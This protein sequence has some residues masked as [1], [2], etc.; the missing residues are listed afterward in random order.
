IYDSYACR[1]DKGTHKAIKRFVDFSHS[2]K[3]VLSMDISKYFASIDHGIL[4]RLLSRRITDDRVFSLCRVVIESSENSP[5]KGIPIGNL[6]SQL[7]AN[8][9]LDVLGQHVK[10][11]LRLRHYIRYMDDFVFFH[12][13]KA[14]L[15]NLKEEITGF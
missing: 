12:N 7:F 9:Y 6:T 10:H 4:L 13:D 3:Y 14:F 15:H 5:G 1:K 8:I 2:S 11:N